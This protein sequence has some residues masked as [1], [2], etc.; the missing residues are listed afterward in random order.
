MTIA[1]FVLKDPSVNL[2]VKEVGLAVTQSIMASNSSVES[3]DIVRLTI[4]MLK[5]NYIA[6]NLGQYIRKLMQR[7]SKIEIAMLLQRLFEYQ[8]V[9]RKTLLLEVLNYDEPLF[10]PVWFQT[11]LWV[12]LF[13]DELGSLARKIW[14]KYGFYL[15]S[16]TMQLAKEK[17]HR[18]LFNYLR[19][20]NY[21]IFN[22]TIK[23]A[24][25]AIELLHHS[26]KVSIISDLI[27]FYDDEWKVIEHL[28]L[29]STKHDV[30]KD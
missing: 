23:A 21:S 20:K 6:N 11:Q 10:C 15:Q 13:D 16:E 7:C 22:C 30:D 8:P 12:L 3:I 2:S 4:N 9:P 17:S 25:S 19:D 28:S 26:P 1:N 14:N 27:E 24:A 18:N 5:T 29:E